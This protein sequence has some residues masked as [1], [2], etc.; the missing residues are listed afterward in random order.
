M[1]K[2]ARIY[3]AGHRGMVGA[4]MIRNLQY[5][6]YTNLITCTRAELPLMKRQPSRRSWG[7]PAKAR[8]RLGWVPEITV[9]DMCAKMVAEDLRTAKRHAMLKADSLQMP[10]ST[11]N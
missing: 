6:G 7:D 1:D 10:I 2:N 9:Q 3:V 8:E 5:A 11:V 4:A